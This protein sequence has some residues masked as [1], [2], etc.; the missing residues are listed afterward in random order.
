MIYRSSA[1]DP[2]LCPYEVLCRICIVQIPSVNHV[3]G[4]A[5]YYMPPTQQREVDHTGTDHTG[6]DQGSI[7]PARHIDIMKWICPRFARLFNHF[8]KRLC[9]LV[10]HNRSFHGR[11]RRCCSTSKRFTARTW[12]RSRCLRSTSPASR[13]RRPRTAFEL[14]CNSLSAPPFPAGARRTTSRPSCR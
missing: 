10:K 4:R 1:V 7:C 14:S 9:Q 6:T 12:P 3:L 13:E 2:N 8:V 11:R 5:G